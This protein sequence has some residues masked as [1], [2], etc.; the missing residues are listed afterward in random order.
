MPE[1]GEWISLRVST[2]AIRTI[3]KKGVYQYI[4]ELN[5]KG[6]QTGIKL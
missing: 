3:N 6:V 1:T 5:A 4:K 2:Q